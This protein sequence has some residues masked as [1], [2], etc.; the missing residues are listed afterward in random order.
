MSM[1]GRLFIFAAYDAGARVGASLLWHLRSLAACGDV[2]LEADS[3]FS[4]GEL[5]KLGGF[6]LHAGGA[7]HGE[8]DFGSYKRAWQWAR[9]N[10]DTDAYDFVYLV[11]DSV[12]G[13]L[14]EL[15]PCLER[16]EGLGCPAF[17]LVMHPSG[18]SPHLQSW[19]M[20]FG[21]EVSG[22]AWFDAFLSSV[23]RQESK[24]AVCEKYENGL[25]RL[26][27][28]H[29]VDFQGLFNLSGKSVY[30]SPLRLYRRG[31]PFVK[32]SSFTRHAGCLGRQLRLVL[33][34]LP[35]PCR[36]AVLSDA[37]RLYGADY[38]DS[39]LAAGRFTV[40][41]R[42]LRYLASKLRGRSA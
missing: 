31:L 26:L 29:G 1:P 18:H 13:P 14:R 34:S 16:M 27:T 28:A 40:V 38:V 19:F 22:A 25:T 21:R 39:L 41:R 3:D 35:A 11:N 32:K 15:E 5:E 12:F 20:G 9:E 37:V 24:E 33:D 4:A 8:Y 36:D 17:G 10:L 7:A 2:V 30:N 6:C 23:E 42:Y